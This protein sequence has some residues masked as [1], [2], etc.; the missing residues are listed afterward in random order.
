MQPNILGSCLT[1]VF[2]FQECYI[3]DL[4]YIFNTTSTKQNF[5]PQKSSLNKLRMM[6]DLHNTVKRSN[7][8]LVTEEEEKTQ[9]E[10]SAHLFQGEVVR[11]L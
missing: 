11:T 4:G 3:A 6:T 10:T 8:E 7:S 2:N 1:D 5:A 9:M